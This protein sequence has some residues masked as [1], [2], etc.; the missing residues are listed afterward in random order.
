MRALLGSAAAQPV[1]HRAAG[2]TIRGQRVVP[3]REV[4][5]LQDRGSSR[6]TSYLRG[7]ETAT[8][9]GAD[10]TVRRWREASFG[11]LLAWFCVILAVVIGSRS[12]IR[13]GVP[14]V[15]Q[16][17][18]FPESP[19]QLLDDYRA[20]FDPRSFGADGGD[21]DGVGGRRLHQRRVAVPHV[22]A[23]DDVGRRLLPARRARGVAPGDGVPGEPGADRRHGRLRRHAAWCPA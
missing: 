20:S 3:E 17:L 22:V 21:P 16:F 1:D 12:F 6:L 9:V 15:G 10:S 19:R 18:P 7:K 5:G 23:D 2:A 4:L 11:P 14:A 13:D 8:F